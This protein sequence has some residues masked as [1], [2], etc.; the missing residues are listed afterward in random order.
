[1][2]VAT[3][4][5]S[6][7]GEERIVA[8]QLQPASP[9]LAHGGHHSR[10]GGAG[11]QEAR[12]RGPHRLAPLHRQQGEV[13]VHALHRGLAVSPRA[14]QHI[15]FVAEGALVLFLAPLDLGQQRGDVIESRV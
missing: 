11:W 1:M 7:L 13:I 3:V 8:E 6:F 15:S 5:A 2:R 9:H 10:V 12:D 14:D 4:P